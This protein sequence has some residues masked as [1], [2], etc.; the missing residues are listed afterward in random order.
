MKHQVVIIKLR[1]KFNIL[2]QKDQ[3][4]GILVSPKGI[5][6]WD[7]TQ[8]L[9]AEN[10]EQD[11][12]EAYFSVPAG[13]RLEWIW[14]VYDLPLKR[15]L[16][17]ESTAKRSLVAPSTDSYMSI[18][19]EGKESPMIPLVKNPVFG[20]TASIKKNSSLT[21]NEDP[22]ASKSQISQKNKKTNSIT[23]TDTQ[24]KTTSMKTQE[25]FCSARTR[26]ESCKD[27]SNNVA[28][29]IS[30]DCEPTQ[31][32]RLLISKRL[33]V[34]PII[35]GGSLLAYTAYRKFC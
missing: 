19:W 27:D 22:V 14:I 5:G 23:F 32:A 15:V 13:T 12:W 30:M 3:C 25:A 20:S 18:P 6:G 24:N 34:L 31:R 8:P 9:L 17:W 4:V 7:D 35:I 33:V 11:Y 29:S 2:D 21:R 1:T 10:V 28:T 26:L 16:R